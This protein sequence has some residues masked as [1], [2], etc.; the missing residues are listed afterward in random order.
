MKLDDAKSGLT[1]KYK[2]Y[3]KREKLEEEK[4]DFGLPTFHFGAVFFRFH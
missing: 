1:A 3:A 2:Q 4:G